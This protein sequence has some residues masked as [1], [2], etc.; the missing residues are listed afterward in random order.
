LS[1]YNRFFFIW[2]FST[3]MYTTLDFSLLIFKMIF[4]FYFWS[5]IFLISNKIILKRENQAGD[6]SSYHKVV[7]NRSCA[8]PPMAFST[9]IFVRFQLEI[10]AK[11]QTPSM[12]HE[13]LTLT[14]SLF[15]SPLNS[16]FLLH[17][18]AE[19]I[20]NNEWTSGTIKTIEFLEKKPLKTD[21]NK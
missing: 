20:P 6:T 14:F 2:P 18:E 15:L 1:L 12:K 19:T 11:C 3:S 21:N 13:L 16:S 4:I 9:T 7:G 5:I 17:I 10:I 8:A